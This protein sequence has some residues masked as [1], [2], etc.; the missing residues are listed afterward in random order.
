MFPINYLFAGGELFLFGV[1][2]VGNMNTKPEQQSSLLTYP[3]AW[4]QLDKFITKISDWNWKWIELAE[5]N[6]VFTICFQADFSVP[7]Y[8]SLN[9]TIHVI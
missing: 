2:V 1:F 9:E 3:I 4:H 8:F 7:A 6:A 5:S